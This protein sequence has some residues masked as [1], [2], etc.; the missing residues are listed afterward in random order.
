MDNITSFEALYE[1][2]HKCKCGVMWK[3]SVA[4]FYLN[5]ICSCLE[6][7]KQLANGTYKPRPTKKVKIT[8][9]KPRTAVSIAFRD[10]VYQRSLNDNA[11]YPAMSKSFIYP[12]MACQKGKG[13]DEARDILK[14]YLRRAWLKHRNDFYVLQCDIKGYFI[15]IDHEIAENQI[16]S[17]VNKANA[18]RACSVLRH[19]YEGDKGY[20]PGSQLV[21]IVGISYLNGLDHYIKERLKIKY[22]IRYQ[23]DFV[24]LHQDKAYL[25][26]CMVLIKQFLAERL[27]LEAHPKKTV[28]YPASKGISFLGFTHRLTET[29][30]VLMLI[31]SNGVKSYRRKMVRM[32]KLIAKGL[33]SKEKFEECY[34]ARRAHV[35]KGNTKKHLAKMDKFYKELLKGVE[36]NVL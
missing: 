16:R 10:R 19:Q 23:D 32:A 11:I 13:P 8:F 18:D 24:L 1:S 30:K 29:G 35:K 3:S 20:N 12:N 31:N 6:L 34:N 4:S 9:P 27:H 26:N 15:N 33:R 7:E 22:Y 21:Q 25:E 5:G 36:G 17:K 14:K 2:M 28:I